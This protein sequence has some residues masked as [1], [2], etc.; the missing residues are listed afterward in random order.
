MKTACRI[1]GLGPRPIALL[2]GI[3]G[4]STP[5]LLRRKAAEEGRR[6]ESPQ[7]VVTIEYAFAVGVYEVTFEEWDR[8]VDVGYEPTGVVEGVL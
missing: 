5:D 1:W 8:G 3:G 7:R 4:A 2:L 6:N